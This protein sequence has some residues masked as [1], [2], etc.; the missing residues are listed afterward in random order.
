[1]TAKNADRIVLVTG[2]GQGIGKGIAKWL[3]EEGTR[4]IIADIDGEAVEET[5]AELGPSCTSVALD[6][7]DEPAVAGVMQLVLTR[8][9]RLDALVNNAGIAAPKAAPVERLEL[10]D[11]N[12]VMSTNLTG[13][14]LCCKHAV[15]LLRRS[16]GAIQGLD[17]SAQKFPQPG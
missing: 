12:R 6:V 13:V 17:S 8:Y 11:W 10:S 9:G 2:G 14:F 15:P 7:A 3:L 4:V 16:K 1:M 5:A